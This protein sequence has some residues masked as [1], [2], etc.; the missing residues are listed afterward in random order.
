MPRKNPYGWQNIQPAAPVAP[1]A[2]VPAAG[3][4]RPSRKWRRML[5]AGLLVGGLSG[6]TVLVVLLLSWSD[7][8]NLVVV[9]P[10]ATLL[11][12]PDTTSGATTADALAEFCRAGKNRP[13]LNAPPILVH[14]GWEKHLSAARGGGLVVYLAA[15]GAADADGPFL[16]WPSAAV[17]TDADKLRVSDI[18]AEL[19]TRSGPKLLVFDLTPGPL[20]WASN[21]ACGE[22]A[23]ALKGMNADLAA[24]PDLAVI[25]SADADETPWHWDAAKTS[26]F[27]HYFAQAI[28]G[29]G[30]SANELVTADRAFEKVAADVNQWSRKQRAVTQ[31]PLLLP[32]AEGPARAKAVTL[33]KVPPNG[34]SPPARPTAPPQDRAA[35]EREWADAERELPHAERLD[36]EGFK[37]YLGWRLRWEQLVR[38]SLPVGG[39]PT[40]VAGLRSRLARGADDVP[41]V[42]LAVPQPAVKLDSL[43]ID[44][45]WKATDDAALR[46]EWKRQTDDGPRPEHA[47]RAAELLCD[48]LDA[49]GCSHANLRTAVRVLDAVEAGMNLRPVETHLLRMFARHLE[50]PDPASVKQ[51]LALRRTAERAAWAGHAG[52][53][54]RWTR[55]RLDDADR[56]RRLGEDL[57]FTGDA[58]LSAEV[59]A[60]F[61]DAEKR[62]ADGQRD[63]TTVADA[64]AARDA[65]LTRL[66]F[67]ARWVADGHRTLRRTDDNAIAASVKQVETAFRAAHEL[68]ALLATPPADPV[69]RA[70]ALAK[71][72]PLTSEANAAF[73]AV[74]DAYEAEVTTLLDA[75]ET[76]PENWHALDTAAA[77]PFLTAD[78]RSKLFDK[79]E[80]V[81]RG[82][83]QPGE[84][85][86]TTPPPVVGTVI[87]ARH[88]A[89]AR[90]LLGGAASD[91]PPTDGKEAAALRDAADQIGRK[92]R[93]FPAA[94]NA[95][96]V[97]VSNAN[98]LTLAEAPL[99]DAARKTRRADPSAPV[100][101]AVDPVLAEG[102]YWRHR[103]LL[104]QAERAV[105]DGWANVGTDTPVVGKDQPINTNGWY[106]T[107][108]AAALVERARVSVLGIVLSPT[109]EQTTRLTADCAALSQRRPHVVTPTAAT[110]FTVI[111]DY[112]RWTFGFDVLENPAVAGAKPPTGYPTLWVKLPEEYRESNPGGIVRE[113]Y[114][115][116]GRSAARSYFTPKKAPAGDQE[117]VSAVLYRGHLAKWNT[118]VAFTGDATIEYVH[119]PPTDDARFA[120]VADDKVIGGAVV[121][122]IDRSASMKWTANNKLRNPTR[123]SLAVSGL[124]KLLDALPIGTAVTVGGFYLNGNTPVVEPIAGPV[125]IDENDRWEKLRL[126]PSKLDAI[127]RAETPIA[128]SI[129]QVLDKDRGRTFWP[130]N[131]AGARSLLVLTDGEDNYDAKRGEKPAA[132]VL[133]AVTQKDHDTHLH[134]VLFA[135][136]G[137]DEKAA[138]AQ[139]GSL[140]EPAQY[141]PGKL[142]VKVWPGVK[143]GDEFAAKLRDQFRP[144]VSF[145][146]VGGKAETG[147]LTATV[148][149]AGTGNTEPS[150]V[151]PSGEYRLASG[152]WEGFAT[153]APGDNLLLRARRGPRNGIEWTVPPSA[154][155]LTPPPLR[156]LGR[157]DKPLR[158]SVPRVGWEGRAAALTV[159][160]ERAPADGQKAQRLNRP[161]FPWMDVT[162]PARPGTLPRMR[163]RNAPAVVAPAWTVV[164]PRWDTGAD[165]TVAVKMPTVT[166]FWIDPRVTESVTP[167]ATGKFR[168]GDILEVPTEVAKGL[169]AR[170]VP[171][172]D[173]PLLILEVDYRQRGAFAYLQTAWGNTNPTQTHRYYDPQH[174]YTATF[175]PLSADQEN[176]EIGYQLYAVADLRTV[177]DSATVEL[178][179]M[180]STDRTQ[181]RTINLRFAPPKQ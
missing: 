66:P 65:V 143:N 136:D 6:L 126:T 149:N 135:M 98:P 178:P 166:G 71:L 99:A 25:C 90:A 79:L 93:S 50:N 122:L 94:A 63:A 121:I 36:P 141:P 159:A 134:I 160:L 120:V 123:T 104:W 117:L 100:A 15:S 21:G 4:A 168:A 3:T 144:R 124:R 175:G 82:L 165:Q 29:T 156:S 169:T 43:D 162:D 131:Y 20:P 1:G 164:L 154:F 57:L 42:S 110:T 47:R 84:P 118:K 116:G 73:Q 106:A 34:Y 62:Y 12:V 49:V 26:V 89:V 53:A 60:H 109:S 70:D 158:L 61:A 22:F 87:A 142:P 27:S 41:L 31:K 127:P 48:K 9:A 180:K 40:T 140:E 17:L 115:G 111:T 114:R 52:A 45:L 101:A 2:T 83:D 16:W 28:R 58:K 44:R 55:E 146:R 157:A 179:A 108:I 13:R 5:I 107:R 153:L 24:V 95:E 103:F 64:L 167:T 96:M 77:V 74:V 80:R 112:P 152:V 170:K 32:T 19:K 67:Y 137:A 176:R 88:V 128:W 119:V 56:V 78:R 130:T 174:R 161:S 39:L 30:R 18:L 105:A 37:Q 172:N 133:R 171:T 81:A 177:A 181:D 7:Y 11:S 69:Q 148:R 92:F 91:I 151:L 23:A 139:F 86:G 97:K 150:R 76:Q 10:R 129:Q 46:V 72:K 173:G 85:L 8:P 51:A 145:A 75:A 132:T 155:D 54:F 138:Q 35:L 38:D 68:D 33:A 147:V 113:A 102:R 59:V 163:V 14:D 125:E